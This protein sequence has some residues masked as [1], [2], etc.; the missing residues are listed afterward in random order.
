MGIVRDLIKAKEGKTFIS[1]SANDT[2]FHALEV[3][4]KYNIGAVLVTEGDQITG[5]FTERDYARLGELKGRQADKTLVK[6]VMTPKVITVTPETRL[7]ECANL[8]RQFNVRHLPVK[9]NDS[10]IGMVSIRGLAEALLREQYALVEKLEDF[11][12]GT[13]YAR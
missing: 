8:M 12:Q 6:E 5:I 3:M 10:I 1:V 7:E 2:V 4:D 13:G 9:E 11:I